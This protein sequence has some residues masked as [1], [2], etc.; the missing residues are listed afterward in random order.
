MCSLPLTAVLD[1]FTVSYR[2]NCSLQGHVV[3]GDKDADLA[4]FVSEMA[5]YAADWR[6]KGWA[7]K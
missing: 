7:G 1:A 5:A 2:F 3:A 6:V 4:A